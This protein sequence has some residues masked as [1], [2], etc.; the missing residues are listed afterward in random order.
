M[1]TAHGDSLHETLHAFEVYATALHPLLDNLE[2]LQ[3]ALSLLLRGDSTGGGVL[4]NLGPLLDRCCMDDVVKWCLEPREGPAAVARVTI[5]EFA[6]SAAADS[7]A[8]WVQMLIDEAPAVLTRTPNLV[9]SKFGNV[10]SGLLK[11]EQASEWLKLLGEQAFAPSSN[12]ATGPLEKSEAFQAFAQ[13]ATAMLPTFSNQS[14]C[15]DAWQVAHRAMLDDA[16]VRKICV[17]QLLPSLACVSHSH[18]EAASRISQMIQAVLGAAEGGKQCLIASIREAL[19]LAVAFSNLLLEHWKLPSLQ[20]DHSKIG[21]V[22]ISDGLRLGLKDCGSLRKQARFLLESAVQRA[23][24]CKE[25]ESQFRQIAGVNLASVASAWR[26]YWELFDTLEDYSSHLIKASWDALSSRLVQYL[27]EL[28][29]GSCLPPMVFNPSW[30]EVFLVRALD[31]DNDSVQKFVLGKLMSLDQRAVCLSESFI[32]TEVLPRFGR[33]IDSLYPRT[34]VE[35]SFEHQ[36]KSFFLGFSAQHPEGAAT[37]ATRLLEALFEVPAIH[38]TPVRLVLSAL[39]EAELD[40]RILTSSRTLELTDRFFSQE[41]LLRMPN[42]IRQLLASIFL[43]VLVHLC[44]DSK[45]SSESAIL[46]AKVAK[47]FAS[48]PDALLV[49]LR[50]D[51]RSVAEMCLAL[52]ADA[53]AACVGMFMNTLV[54]SDDG[55]LPMEAAQLSLGAVRLLWALQS[56]KDFF[57]SLAWPA[58]VPALQDLHRRSYMPRRTAV[59][60]LYILAYSASLWPEASTQVDLH[61]EARSEIL[62]YVE[63]KALISIGQGRPEEVVQEAPWVWLYA[64]VLERFWHPSAQV[65]QVLLTHTKSLLQEEVGTGAAAVLSHV[66]AASLLGA[67]APKVDVAEQCKIFHLLCQFQAPGKPAGVADSRFVIGVTEEHGHW[68]RLRLEEFEDLHRMQREGLGRIQ[69]WRD[70]SAVVLVAKWR[71]LAQIASS[72]GFYDGLAA[73]GGIVEVAAEILLELDSLQTPHVAYWAIV[74]RRLA[75]PAY[76]Q[77]KAILGEKQEEMLQ[78]LCRCIRGFISQSIGDSAIVMSRG[79]ML[80]LCGALCDPELR[81]AEQRLHSR[82]LTSSVAELLALGEVGT[83]VSRSL[84]VPLLS[85]LF[86]ETSLPDGAEESVA[87]AADLLTAL[88]MHSEYT[89]K[90][91]AFCH[92]T[93]PCTGALDDDGPGG[94]ATLAATV[95]D[96]E[97]L[98]AKFGGTTGLPRIM[99]L[100]ALDGFARTST[101]QGHVRIPA[102]IREILI[103]LLEALRKE[104]QALLDRPGGANKPLTPMPLSPQHRLQLR[105]WQAVLILGCHAQKDKETAEMLLSELFWHLRTPHLPD[106]RDYQELL[107]CLLCRSF[108]DLAMQH[109][110][111]ALGCYHC[112][113][114]VSASLLVISSFLFRDWVSSPPPFPHLPLLVAVV[115]YLGHNSAYVRGTASWGFYELI[116]AAKNN[117]SFPDGDASQRLL[118]ELHSFL[119]TNRECQKMRRR[120]RPIFLSYDT[121]KS[122]LA[123]L[124]KLS[125]VLPSDGKEILQPL[126]IFANGDFKPSQTFLE[127]LKDEV[128]Q[129]MERIF[130]GEDPSQYSSSSEH[131]QEAQLAALRAVRQLQGP[132]EEEQEAT[133][134]VHAAGGASGLQRKFVPPAPPRLPD[135]AGGASTSKRAPL[136]VLASLVDKLPNLAGLSRTCEVFHCEALCLP[137]LK[138]VSEQAFQSISVT[139][140]KWLPLRGVP[141]S[142][143]KEHLLELRR[144]GYI[145]LGVEQTHTSVPLDQSGPTENPGKSER[146]VDET[147]GREF[148]LFMYSFSMLQSSV[149]H[150]GSGFGFAQVAIFR[151]HSDIARQDLH[152]SWSFGA[153]SQTMQQVPRRRVSMP[154]CCLYSTD[155]WRFLNK[156]NYDPSTS[157]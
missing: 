82:A 126:H 102:L 31:H 6:A 132:V 100:A 104:L 110:I 48:I 25:A 79:C 32:L 93:L 142:Q 133:G 109:L 38:Y 127:L 111:P 139:A 29:K 2:S 49:P 14:M 26:S 91:G 63:G 55:M 97:A 143:L 87:S 148:C 34:D 135:D 95:P 124:T 56:G 155:A 106:V 41:M 140:E 28:P 61:S 52:D 118:L 37:A 112:N 129:E 154:I 19:N 73:S 78:N 128:A 134:L 27:A 4:V 58:I 119:A 17:Q 20:G 156:G 18:Q 72:A 53:A 42:S 76:F 54:S 81:A 136:V 1:A 16:T 96:A 5:L 40:K 150:T 84:T 60:A 44:I 64:L 130:E 157:M 116:E 149:E 57:V 144:S 99:A 23:L 15:S 85:M 30:L 74:A 67:M 50:H 83:G 11:E 107:G 77:S 117:G 33:G 46:V 21:V 138:V 153:L 43:R 80:E 7:T 103:R 114:Q 89:I 35:R 75:Y 88:V 92:S 39:I 120:L 65:C 122:A 12:T 152:C 24:A 94:Q 69:E 51:L 151:A 90:D 145:L 141:K 13:A 101:S 123:A 71:A 108:Q 47:T 125:E 68:D 147:C 9:P 105:G 36:V 3:K 59:S 22:L 121:S 45:D 113:N 115:P 137:N 146:R 131:W 62:S 8:S 98:C 66:A 10:L 70:A 86:A